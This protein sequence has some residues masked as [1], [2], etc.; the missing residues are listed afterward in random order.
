MLAICKVW[1]P[2][3]LGLVRHPRLVINFDVGNVNRFHKVV[4]VAYEELADK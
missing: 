4:R 2:I 1:L 3:S